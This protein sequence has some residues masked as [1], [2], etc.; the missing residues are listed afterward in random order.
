[1]PAY[2]FMYNLYALARNAAK[3]GDRDKRTEKI[4]H[5][6]FDYLAPDTAEEM[7]HALIIIE[8]AVGEALV[9]SGEQ[10]PAGKSMAAFG[11]QALKA[12]DKKILNL[13]VYVKGFENSKRKTQLLKVL[14]AY[15]TYERMLIFYGLRALIQL[16]EHTNC[17]KIEDLRQSITLLPL[18]EKWVNVGGQLFSEGRLEQLLQKIRKGTVRSWEQVHGFYQAQGELY[19]QEKQRHALA[20][21]QKITGCRMKKI[22][23]QELA[24]F[25]NTAIQLERS[26]AGGIRQSRMKDYE[27]PYRKMLYE[28]EKEMFTVLGNPN[29]NAFLL[30]QAKLSKQFAA[31]IRQIRKRMHLTD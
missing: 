25:L 4:Q 16:V 27:N 23:A 6:E 17:K 1:M 31:S 14:P 2:W 12:G 29:D 7:L 26:I 11:K 22:T 8:N 28:N 13:P 19:E 3:Y 30:Q 18:K 24:A 5:L 15:Q 10:L 20:V 9:A 21:L